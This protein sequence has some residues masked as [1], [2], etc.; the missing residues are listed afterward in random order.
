ML[1]FKYPKTFH[2]PESKTTT[3]D[4][5]ILKSMDHFIGKSIVITEK[6]D[7]ENTTIAKDYYH[8]RSIDSK[9][10]I[11]RRF[12]KRCW[13]EMRHNIPDKMRIC[14]ENLFAT[15]SIPYNNLKSYFEV[16]SIWNETHCLS[17][18]ETIEYCELL[19]L[20]TVPV[21]Y[22]G[23]YDENVIMFLIDTLN[24]DTQEG[25]VVR[26]SDGFEYN[27]FSKSIAKYVRENHVVTDKHWM[28][29]ELKI[30]KL[31]EG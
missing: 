20:I 12:V 8:A 17:W 26:L 29:K 9:D 6:R 2:L 24:V 25:F 19:N 14:G 18:A 10:H 23:I 4:D 15:H 3:S 5:K 16:F 13:G 21:L 1:K 27:D 28:F 30:N 7:G 11:S 22:E 31:L